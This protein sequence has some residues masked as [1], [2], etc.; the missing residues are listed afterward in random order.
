MVRIVAAHLSN[1]QVIPDEPL[2]AEDEVDKISIVLQVKE[3]GARKRESF[4]DKWFGA[5]KGSS[6]DP[7]GEYK[8]YLEQKYL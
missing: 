6:D 5:L 3:N 2:P 8:K 7:E 1:G 4:V